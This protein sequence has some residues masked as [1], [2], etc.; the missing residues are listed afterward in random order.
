[1]TK[2]RLVHS[3]ISRLKL[4]RGT[5]GSQLLEFAFSLPFL[6][7][8]AV[9]VTDFGEAYNLKHIL[10]NAA[11]EAARITVSNPLSNTN[12]ADPVGL[13]N[14]CSVQAAAD[15]AKQYM[16]NANLSLASCITPN[17][18][19]AGTLTWT[20]SCSGITL[21][22]NRGYVFTATSG[23]VVPSTQVTLTY[24]YTWTFGKLIGLLV[25]GSTPTLPT[26][27]TT[28]LIMQ[29]LVAQ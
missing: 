17:A 27:L 8:L 13:T 29:N 1:M 12:C 11:R 9:G 21:T 6:V 26:N 16:L 7:V 18:P 24:P 10:T 15:A 22:I 5:R 19:T 3:T 23:N 25:P 4:L 28:S 20:Y 2:I 14:P